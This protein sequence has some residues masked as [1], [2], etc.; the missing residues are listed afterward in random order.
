VKDLEL[1]KDK[2]T[3][4]AAAVM[5]VKDTKET[6]SFENGHM[7]M[8][9]TTT[10]QVDV[11]EVRK[12]LAARQGDASVRDDVAMQKE[13]LKRLEAQLEAMQQHQG[14]QSS[15]HTP[16]YP[17]SDISAADLQILRKQAAQGSATAEYELG[18]RYIVGSGVSK[19][20]ALARQW[21]QKAAD[22][23]NVAG[24]VYLGMLYD[25][26]LGVPHDAAQAA[27]WY[28]KAAAQGDVMAQDALGALYAKGDGVSQDNVRAYM[29]FSL[30][31]AIGHAGRNDLERQMTPVQIAESQQL[32]REWKPKTP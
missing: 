7:T 23:G 32:A 19:D 8:T 18:G 22:Q 30:A 5:Q 9:L 13:R 28:E 21:I 17:P 6:V 27:K 1:T 16:A 15:G 14:G 31:G 2:I 26:G 20:S 11:G 25:R 24:Q 3:S 12:Q 29:W 4:F 10:A